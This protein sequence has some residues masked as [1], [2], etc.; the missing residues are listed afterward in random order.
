MERYTEPGMSSLLRRHRQRVRKSPVVE[1]KRKRK[2]EGG[3]E[4]VQIDPGP[5]FRESLNLKRQPVPCDVRSIVPPHLDQRL[6][7]HT[8]SHTDTHTPLAL[9]PSKLSEDGRRDERA[10]RH[11]QPESRACVGV[12]ACLRAEPTCTVMALHTAAACSRFDWVQARCKTS[13]S[14]VGC[15]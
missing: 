4:G 8:H 6:S 15:L 9:F 1:P 3:V 5:V 12:R 2:Q 7:S 14:K 13:A 11:E 10:G